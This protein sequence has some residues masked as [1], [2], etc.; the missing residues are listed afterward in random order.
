MSAGPATPRARME[1]ARIVIDHVSGS[2]RGKRQELP[3]S[4]R[5][6]FG[7]HPDNEVAFHARR[8]LDA[9]SRHAELLPEGDAYVLRDLGSS[10][11]T[12]VAGRARAEIPIARNT[13][14]TVAFGARGPV[15]RIYIGARPPEPVPGGVLRRL[16]DRIRGARVWPLWLSLSLGL[17]APVAWVSLV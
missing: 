17:T 6:R 1:E 2:Q 3:L 11:G 13:P 12:L 16:W 5:V 10:N 4:T 15:V 7:R 14:V 9:S 8:D